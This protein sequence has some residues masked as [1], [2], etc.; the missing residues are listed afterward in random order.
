MTHEREFDRRHPRT[1]SRASE[2]EIAPNRETRSARLDAP[3]HPI[4]SGLLQRQRD[5]NGVASDAEHAVARA[6]SSTG[7][8]LP[9]ALLRKFEASLGADLSSVRVHTGAASASAAHAV[10]AKAYTLGQ[11]IHFGAG[12][13]DPSGNEHLIAH[14]VAHTVQQRGVAAT[15]QHKLEVSAPADHG[16]HEA[17]AAADAMIRGRS[18]ALSRAPVM[19]ARDPLKDPAT[20]APAAAEPENP[21][22]LTALQT[23]CTAAKPAL[24]AKTTGK[25]AAIKAAVS[26]ASTAAMAAAAGP[27]ADAISA[28]EKIANAGREELDGYDAQVMGTRE[29]T[30]ADTACNTLDVEINNQAAAILNEL[31]IPGATITAGAPAGGNSL[32]ADIRSRVRVLGSRLDAANQL[33]TTASAAGSKTGKARLDAA[34]AVRA[35]L[36][37]LNPAE[38]AFVVSVLKAGGVAA[39][40]M[41]FLDGSGA[42]LRKAAGV[43]ELSAGGGNSAVEA[44]KQGAPSPN[45]DVAIAGVKPKLDLA[46]GELGGVDNNGKNTIGGSVKVRADDGSARFEGA[47]F[48]AAHTVAGEPTVKVSGAHTQTTTPPVFDGTKWIVAY[49]ITTTAGVGVGGQSTGTPGN[50]Q[51]NGKPEGP[52][53]SVGGDARLSAKQIKGGS[54]V[55]ATEAEAKAFYA[56]GNTELLDPEVLSHALPNA[57]Q[58]AALK[59]GETATMAT[60]VG[61]GASVSGGA[62][63]VTASAGATTD[64]DKEVK[65]TKKDDQKIQ[66]TFR[67]ITQYGGSAGVGTTGVAGSAG[68]G[69]AKATSVT[70]EFDLAIPEAKAA[71]ARWSAAADIAPTPGPGVKI[72][73][74]GTGDFS[75]KSAGIAVGV[76][77]V[78]GNA[79]DTSTTGEFVEKSEDGKHAQSTVVGSSTTASKGFNPLNPDKQSRTDSLEIVTTDG[80]AASATFTTKASIQDQNDAK[81]ANLELGKV[82]GESS[83]AGQSLD[84]QKSSGTTG[85]WSVDGS[86]S[87]AQMT[88]FQN[89]VARGEFSVGDKGADLKA[90]LGDARK[91]DAE[92]QAATAAWYAKRGPDASKELREAI[93]APKLAVTLDGDRFMTGAAGQA[94]FDGKLAALEQR[95]QDSKLAGDA[96]KTLL[97]DVVALYADLLEKRDHIASPANYPE[98]PNGLRHELVKQ[99]SANYGAVQQLRGRVAAKAKTDGL[100]DVSGSP[101]LNRKMAE[102]NRLRVAAATARS[103]A[104]DR[105]RKH[106][107]A[108]SAGIDSPRAEIHSDKR[109]NKNK[110]ERLVLAHYVEADAAW[111]DGLTHM[112]AAEAHER[113]MFR[114]DCLA[115]ASQNIAIKAAGDAIASYRVASTDFLKCRLVLD[116]I[117]QDTK[118]AL[119]KQ[120]AGYDVQSYGTL[121]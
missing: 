82:L 106:D 71:Y 97:R 22:T 91:T 41:D 6:G 92:K 113:A 83:T 100:G 94:V 87:K 84:G 42:E 72:I 52:K 49:T 2:L 24:V 57:T 32:A 69:G 35:Q 55:F 10:G 54:K 13:Y 47:K 48:E 74:R 27:A 21:S 43:P 25:A 34:Q 104:L 31:T 61:V 16:E 80:N 108:Q 14:E 99:V 101:E 75:S 90:I 18:F 59:A 56:K 20:A 64:R 102:V 66:V 68:G 19:V 45:P 89:K 29:W 114:E 51:L 23:K 38:R 115:T 5:G 62:S 93:G 96:I 37:A 95:L 50:T 28:A 7:S 33:R 15:R 36:T 118:K 116:V 117:Y 70:A 76:P 8:A 121:D 30:A 26:A 53:A 107:G 88:E 103:S 17:D 111:R 112:D 77:F 81:A 63:G 9:D 85:K 11:D 3:A 46:G 67:A 65:I 1:A 120:F 39:D 86:Y 4:A 40:V 110:G 73:S 12:H 109:P 58:L 98:L 78:N 60:G 44:G 79:S 105:R 119:A